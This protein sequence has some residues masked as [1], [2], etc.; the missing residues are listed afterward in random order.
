MPGT[1]VQRHELDDL[2]VAPHQQ[3]SGN[4]QVPDFLIEGALFEVEGIAKNCSMP[5]PPNC[6]G[7]KLM[8]WIIRTF[9]GQ[10]VRTL[11]AVG[12]RHVM[13]ALNESTYGVYFHGAMGG[14]GSRGR[15]CR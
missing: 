12:G 7:G 10:T 9:W 11:I 4:L 5:G 3:M 15:W 1:P 14:A 8:E 13:R 6:P 2:A